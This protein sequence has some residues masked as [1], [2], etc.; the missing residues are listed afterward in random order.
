MGGRLADLPPGVALDVVPGYEA[1][2]A[3]AFGAAM[4]DWLADGQP[5]VE[6]GP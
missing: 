4:V 6:T 2:A 5:A 3:A 1:A